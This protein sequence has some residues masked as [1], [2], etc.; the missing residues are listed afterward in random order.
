MLAI[1]QA[2]YYLSLLRIVGIVTGVAFATAL[3][4]IFLYLIYFYSSYWR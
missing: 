4:S 1:T 2:D 3:I